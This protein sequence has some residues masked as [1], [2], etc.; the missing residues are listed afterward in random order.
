MKPPAPVDAAPS[1]LDPPAW[2]NTT[3]PPQRFVKRE[4]TMV[5]LLCLASAL[6][7]LVFSAAFPFFGPQDEV[8]HFDLV[9]KYAR[10]EVPRGLEPFETQTRRLVVLYQTP[11]YSAPPVPES[12]TRPPLWTAPPEIRERAV[13]AFAPLVWWPNHEV[14]EPPL[15]YAVG[16]V[17]Y[18]LGRAL[19]VSDDHA[20]CWTRLLNTM[21]AG[22]LP[23]L[24]W[25]FVRRVEP[26]RRFVRQGAPL[27]VAFFPQDAFY[28]VNNDAPSAVVVGAA[29]HGLLGIALAPT[30]RLAICVAAGLLVSAALLV[31][32]S[33][34]AIL[35]ALA[36]VLVVRLR[37]GSGRAS[38]P[39]LALVA[40]SIV[41]AASWFSRSYFVF[42]DFSGLSQRAAFLG[43]TRQPLSEIV[44]HPIFRPTGMVAFFHDLMSTYWRG[45]LFWHS[46]PL[47]HASL[48]VAYSAS[49]AILV[50]LAI[51]A[52]WD[53]TRGDTDHA[54]RLGVWM[55]FTVL[56]VSVLFLAAL[57]PLYDYGHTVRPSRAHPYWSVGR[58]MAGT[59]VPFV[60]LYVGG[61]DWG[62]RKVGLGRLTL[63]LLVTFI[64]VITGSRLVL[65]MPAFGSA[66]NCFHLLGAVAGH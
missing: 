2:R 37:S 12:P 44:H 56:A 24:A 60:T 30:P 27:L 31:K 21:A 25:A 14:G 6:R 46:T 34:V 26:D 10:G 58:L 11:E 62:L 47:R 18:S 9:L 4:R 55:S 35:A 66:Y 28:Y 5:L 7:V 42:G 45:E 43:W 41:P 59:I 1:R 40:A 53:G 61:L 13:R 64:V 39:L 17:W 16:A 65:S 8:A 57:S 22:A 48:D 29:L 52:V 32:L 19:G 36:V 23:W 63:P 20:V 54:R 49:S 3:S 51:V 38:G 15:F 33:N 50:F